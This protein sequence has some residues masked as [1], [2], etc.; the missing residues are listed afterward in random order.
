MSGSLNEVIEWLESL[1]EAAAVSNSRNREDHVK[2][3]QAR[4]DVLTNNDNNDK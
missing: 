3:I 1:K 4:I 2:S